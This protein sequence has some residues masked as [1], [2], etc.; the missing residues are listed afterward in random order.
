MTRDT[1][2]QHMRAAE[3]LDELIVLGELVQTVA[4]QS[5]DDPEK[6]PSR[7][8]EAIGRLTMRLAS[9]ATERL[10]DI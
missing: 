1:S 2:D 6:L 3:C 5:R 9:E 8:V 10:G 7:W 4:D